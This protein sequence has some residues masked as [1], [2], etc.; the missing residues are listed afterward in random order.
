MKDDNCIFCKLAGGDIPTATVYED[1]LFRVVLDTNPASKGHALVLPKDHYK[2]IC[3]IDEELAG[4][5]MVLA[6]KVGQAQ[7]KALGSAGFNIVQNNG[8]AA[9]QTVFHLHIHVIPRYEG[10]P[11]MVCWEPGISDPGELA[12]TASAIGEA[13]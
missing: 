8:P 10:G 13:M 9:G 5:A 1:D 6:A 12:S 3:G 11:E 7:M 4:K 2:D